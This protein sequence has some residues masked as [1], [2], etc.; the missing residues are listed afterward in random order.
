MIIKRAKSSDIALLH[1]IETELFTVENFPLSKSSFRYHIKNSLL[2][3]AE[4]DDNI[5][6]YILVLIKRKNAKLYS[7]G[8]LEQYRGKKIAEKLLKVASCELI[9]LGFSSLFLEVRVDNE[10][11][12]SL[13]KRVGFNMIKKIKGFYL[14]SCDA[15]L[16]E[17]KYADK[18][19]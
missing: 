5:A 10:A 17:L 18:T 1:R 19:L 14:D 4:I 13:Y 3:I 8:I 16:M 15:Y 6:G 9:S 12:I 2:Y 11:A 7:I